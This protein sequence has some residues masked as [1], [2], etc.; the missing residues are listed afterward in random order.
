MIRKVYI[1]GII[2]LHT[3]LKIIL[4]SSFPNCPELN[5]HTL[6]SPLQHLVQQAISFC[7]HSA[8]SFKSAA[9]SSCLP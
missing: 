5:V 2:F 9:V 1:M 4:R 3:D 7:I 6:L 8:Q